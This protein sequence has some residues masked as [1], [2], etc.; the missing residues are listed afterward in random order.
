MRKQNNCMELVLNIEETTPRTYI[1]TTTELQYQDNQKINVMGSIVGHYCYK[2]V[3][4]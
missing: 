4:K 3:E 2:K 1:F